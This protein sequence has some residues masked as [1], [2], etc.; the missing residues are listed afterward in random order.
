MLSQAVTNQIGQQR[1]ARHE[2]ADTS[3]IREFLGMNPP[4]F[5]GSSTTEDP[6][7]FIEELKKNFDVMHVADT[8][9]V[10][11]AAYQLKDI[12]RA[13]FDQWK[14]GRV[15][16]APPASWACFEE[17]FLGHFFPRELKEAKVREFLT[18]KEESLSVHEYSLKF[19]QLSRYAPEMV[20][21]MRNIMSLFVAGLS[22]LLS[23]EGR[24]AMLIGDMDMSRLMVY[25]QQVEEEKLRDREEFR[26]KR[27]KTG[28]ES[29]QQKVHLHPEIKVGTRDGIHRTSELDLHSLRMA[30]GSNWGL[31]C[32]R[33]GRVHP[34][35]CHQGQTGCF[36]CGQEGHFTK[37]CPKSKQCS[38]NLGCRAQFSSVAPPDRTA[39]RG[40][41]FSTGGGA[42]RLYAITSRHEQE[43]SPNVVTERVYRDCPVS[44]NHKSTM[45]DLVELDM[46]DFDVI[47]VPIVREFPEVFP[48][49]LP[50]IPPEREID[51][52]IDLI[53]DTRPISIPPYRMSP[54]ELKELK[55][56]LKDLLDKGFIRPIV[57]LWGAPILF[58]RK[59]DGSLRICIDYRLLN[60]VTIKNKYPLPRIDDLFDQLQGA[61]YFSKIDLRSGYHQ[62]RVGECDIPKTAFRTIY[63][64]YMF[65]VMSFGLT[66]APAAFMDLMNKVFKPYLDMFVIVFID[67]ILIYSRNEENHASHLRIVLQTLKDKEL[68]A[69]F[70]KC[71][72]WLESVAFLGHIVSG[73]GIKVDTRKIE[74]VQNWPRPT[75]PTEIR[76]FLGLAGYYRRFI[77]G[78]SSIAS[79]LTKLTQK[80]VKFQWSE[81]C[82]KSFQ[83]LKKR[84][85]TAP[86]LTLPE[87]WQSYSL[88]LQTKE[89]NLRQRRW[90][91]L[92]KDYDLSILYHPGKANV[93]ADALSRLSMGSTTHIEEGKRELAKDVHRLACL[94]IRLIDSAEGGIA[95]ANGAESSLVSEVKEK[96]DQ[97][98]ILL[99][100]KANVQ[101]QRVLAFE[102]GGDGVLRY[103]G[104]LCVPMVDELQERIMEE[105]HSSRYSIHPGTTKMYRDLREVYWWNGMKKD[106]AEFVAKCPN[107]QQVKVKHQRPGGLAQRIELLEWKW[108]MINMDFITG[109]PRSR[110]QH[111][112]IWKGLGSKVNLS[113][114]FHPQTDGQTE[115][116]IQTIED[117]LRACV[118]DFKGSWDD[119]LPLIEF[120]YNNSYHSSIQMAP[121]EALYGR[122]CRSP[123]GWFEV[124]E[125]G[126]IGPDL[127]HQAV[128]K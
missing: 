91:E 27:A 12:A 120:A 97:D 99:E 37:E 83:E 62:L 23:K 72:F 127:V 63:G 108:E 61:T 101:K 111:D 69:K 39:P 17:A 26:N 88:C 122:R 84:L 57:S 46:V 70:S 90:L 51:F 44:I 103:Q 22:R 124:G 73:D 77:E 30:Q 16:N 38:G 13:W 1:G 75:S 65:L 47:L 71:E 105:A 87:E 3:R 118:I 52:G 81:A 125:T 10:E 92:L 95:V 34:G 9:R 31:A 41:T 100:L 66:N 7:H 74:A 29:G 86:V 5:M 6:E 104:R 116:T 128:E 113:T 121:Y 56:Q 82:E 14:C 21:N 8:D 28:N 114:A 18:L 32:A 112:S 50:G 106:I 48:D 76:S 20:A 79:P 102:Q 43:N 25:V 64:H 60:K 58:V 11:L 19:T 78:F 107:C 123:I 117:M 54:A 2:G 85:I 80:T 119:H 45:A 110:R 40:A 67:D 68:Y 59:K 49:Y 93:V 42:N 4:S 53:P 115:R 109:L 126:L 15:E 89:L 35:K 98:P 33:C 36:N 55:E 94:G 24:A 96:Q